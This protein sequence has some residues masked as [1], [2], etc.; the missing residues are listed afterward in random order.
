MVKVKKKRKRIIFVI[1]LLCL[2]MLFIV[3]QFDAPPIEN[4]YSLDDLPSVSE[5]S[6]ESHYLLMTLKDPNSADNESLFEVIQ[7][8]AGDA[9][10]DYSHEEIQE[11]MAEMTPWGTSPAADASSRINGLGLTGEEVQFIDDC[12]YQI[13]FHKLGE[14]FGILRPHTESITQVWLSARTSRETMEKLDT[15]AEVAD[16]SSPAFQDVYDKDSKL[17]TENLKILLRLYWLQSI[18]LWQEGNQIEC[19]RQIILFDSVVR[20]LCKNART[21]LTKYVCQEILRGNHTFLNTFLNLPDIRLE[22]LEIIQRDFP[23]LAEKTLSIRTPLLFEYLRFKDSVRH[24]ERAFEEARW[25]IDASLMRMLFKSNSAIQLY[26]GLLFEPDYHYNDTWPTIYPN[27]EVFEGERFESLSLMARIYNPIGFALVSVMFPIYEPIDR[28]SH[29]VQA[30]RNVF[31]CILE[32]RMNGD[33][34]VLP[35]IEKEGF[36]YDARERK[37]C[38]QK[39][40]E[41]G[42]LDYELKFHI[43]PAVMGLAEDNSENP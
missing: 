13:D 31:H 7:S 18:L 34:D 6:H 30:E 22:T 12:L 17:P 20:K 14:D 43:N 25:R 21:L 15:F 38:L 40:D 33:F 41:A 26:H 42:Y 19:V 16:L 8:I 11:H 1:G 2:A 23:P 24:T 27:F 4:D 36:K 35:A 9:E 39:Y 5:E 3:W 29:H 10:A 32:K 37:F 28:A